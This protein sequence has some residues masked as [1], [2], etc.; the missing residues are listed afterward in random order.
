MWFL[1]ALIDIIHFDRFQ[2]YVVRDNY[3]QVKF[4]RFGEVE[5]SFLVGCDGVYSRV[6]FFKKP[7][8]YL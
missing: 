4:D 8:L 6:S 3:V 2:S 1:K 7:C 5:G